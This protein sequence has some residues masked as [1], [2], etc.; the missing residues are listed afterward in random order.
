MK[1]MMGRLNLSAEAHEAQGLAV[2]FGMGAAEI[3]EEVPLGVAALLVPMT[4]T[5]LAAEPGEPAGMEW[6]SA[7][8]GRRGVRRNP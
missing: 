5:W 3:A 2:A 8:G 4:M 1:V 6:S 7:T